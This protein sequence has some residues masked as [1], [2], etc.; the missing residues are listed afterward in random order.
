MTTRRTVLKTCL[1]LLAAPLAMLWPKRTE[2]GT[3]TVKFAGLDGP[4]LK[5]APIYRPVEGKCD[6]CGMPFDGYIFTFDAE[7]HQ[8]GQVPYHGPGPSMCT[9]QPVIFKNVSLSFRRSPFPPRPDI[10]PH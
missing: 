6:I 1:A 4:P 3:C 2:P 10:A 5:N 7:G 8:I 9:R